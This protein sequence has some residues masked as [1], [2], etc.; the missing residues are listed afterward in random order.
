[1]VDLTNPSPAL[2]WAHCER[3][4]L[5]Q[6][7]PADVVL[8]LGLVH[9]LAISNNTPLAHVA[10]LFAQVGR[11]LIVEWVPKHDG[12]VQKL[13]ASRGDGFDTYQQPHF[14]QAFSRSF[15]IHGAAAVEGSQRVIYLMQTR[16][17]L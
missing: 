2:G 16:E 17:G 11:W 3:M 5:A 7:G 14:E 1:M 6:R 10:A 8:A 9:H 4:S 12:Q 15:V 13:L